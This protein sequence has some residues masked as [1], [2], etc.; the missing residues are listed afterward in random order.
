VYSKTKKFVLFENCLYKCILL[1]ES[2]E[3]SSRNHF[4]EI[5]MK[6]FNMNP[7]EFIIRV[8]QKKIVQH[9]E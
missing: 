8:A 3:E 7:Y 9:S 2:K 5:I 4:Y 6:D 1:L